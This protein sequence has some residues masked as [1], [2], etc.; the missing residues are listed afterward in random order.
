MP[1]E[2]QDPWDIPVVKPV[3]E[4]R[5]ERIEELVLMLERAADGM[6]GLLDISLDETGQF[7]AYPTARITQ[8]WIGE[9]DF[10]IVIG[11]EEISRGERNGDE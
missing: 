9:P 5:R 3:A 11:F 1:G 8:L 2:K 6:R 10:R 4:I 7:T